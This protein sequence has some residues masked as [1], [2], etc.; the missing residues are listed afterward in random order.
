M[1]LEVSQPAAA[2]KGSRSRRNCF[3]V[4][5]PTAG[6]PVDGWPVITVDESR[7][8]YVCYAN[9][10]CPS[11]GAHHVQG[12]VEWTGTL[13]PA[14]K[15]AALGQPAEG[16]FVGFLIAHGTLIENQA[17][18]SKEGRGLVQLGVPREPG[19]PREL[20]ELQAAVR[21]GISVEKLV[22]ED[23]KYG[24]AFVRSYR[25][26]REY[27][28]VMHDSNALRAMPHVA[29]HI[30]PGGC[31]KTSLARTLCIQSGWR[32]AAV[33]DI[34]GNGGNGWFN[35]YTDHEALIFDNV[36]RDWKFSYNFLM[37]ICDR[38]NCNV[39]T[40][41]GFVNLKNLKAIF[42]TSV[43]NYDEWFLE[44]DPAQQAP[45][46]RC[47]NITEFERRICVVRKEF[48]TVNGW[49]EIAFQEWDSYGNWTLSVTK[50]NLNEN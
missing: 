14:Q 16:N 46:K 20:K 29:I 3:V 31:G 39:P 38:Y 15:R 41:G 30:G 43:D 9:E 10:I 13:S 50:F 4:H 22:R 5:L 8:S 2:S 1:A 21:K 12:Y 36:G 40:K 35:S 11:T 48:K 24:S 28:N 26:L 47:R 44:P 33:D 19:K 7:V 34:D 32:Y 25:G 17:Y 42:F 27:A 6:N 45:A 23:E 18:C 37:R 49:N